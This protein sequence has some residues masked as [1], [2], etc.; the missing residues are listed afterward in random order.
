[1][2]RCAGHGEYSHARIALAKDAKLNDVLRQLLP[3][4]EIHGVQEEVP[5]MH[6]IF[7]KVVSAHRPEEVTAGM[8]E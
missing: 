8:T 3:S 6:D 1:M 5:R 2:A 7:I 4:V